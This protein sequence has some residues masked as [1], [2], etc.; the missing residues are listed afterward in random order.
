MSNLDNG[1]N[2]SVFND[3][4]VFISDII[5]FEH[6]PNYYVTGHVSWSCGYMISKDI[7]YLILYDVSFLMVYYN[8]FYDAHKLKN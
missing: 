3:L 2:E 7:Q 5:Y 8:S 4:I 6:L 1:N